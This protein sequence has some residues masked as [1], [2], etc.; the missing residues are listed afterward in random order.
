MPPFYT[1]V[2]GCQFGDVHVAHAGKNDQSFANFVE[3]FAKNLKI[4]ALEIVN[5]ERLV[6]LV[7]LITVQSSYDHR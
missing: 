6:P 4:K 5:L 7:P 2:G 1:E 3:C